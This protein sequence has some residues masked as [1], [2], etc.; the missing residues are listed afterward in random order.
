MKREKIHVEMTIKTTDEGYAV[1]ADFRAQGETIAI[2]SLFYE[3]ASSKYDTLRMAL[4]ELL[5]V[6]DADVVIF[7]S[8]MQQFR[9]PA[10]LKRMLGVLAE[11]KVIVIGKIRVKSSAFLLAK[12]AA[13]RSPKENIIEILEG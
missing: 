12:D 13:K 11:G 6:A 4:R 9:Y 5:K 7:R 1:G 3:A 2:A 8:G 10:R